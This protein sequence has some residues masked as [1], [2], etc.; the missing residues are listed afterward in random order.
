MKDYGFIFRDDEELRKKA[1]VISELTKDISE[2]ILESLK[3]NIKSKGKKYKVA[4]H[5]CLLYTSPSPRD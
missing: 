4:Y 1:K 3:L 2:Y 5:S